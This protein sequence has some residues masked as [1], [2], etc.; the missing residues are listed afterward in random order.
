[1]A[2]EEIKTGAE[3]VVDLEKV[4]DEKC[5]PLTRVIFKELSTSM[6]PE[7]AS[8]S[9]T[10]QAD[11][12]MKVLSLFLA[13][14]LNMTSDTTYI[15]QLLL[16]LLAALNLA[17]QDHDVVVQPDDVRFNIIS[18]KV[19]AIL[20]DEEIPMGM[21]VKTSD[22]ETA[23]VPMKEKLKALFA[24]EN[25]TSLEVTYVINNIFAAFNSVNS[26]VA[27]SLEESLARAEAKLFEVDAM[28]QLGTKKLNEVLLS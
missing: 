8:P 7:D 19:M 27:R 23:I 16:G 18:R 6:I 12:A 4:R 22:V 1:M 21:E 14:D 11:S 5:V 15:P 13:E 9:S 20:A 24:E 3:Q 26:M 17:V 28:T 25:M 2:D 10:A